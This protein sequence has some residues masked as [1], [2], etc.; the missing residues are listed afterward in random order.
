MRSSFYLTN[1]VIDMTSERLCIVIAIEKRWKD[2][3][4]NRRGHEQRV[5]LQSVDDLI[6]NF[7]CER[8]VLGQLQ[9]VLG[10][11]RLITSCDAAIDPVGL[12]QPLAKLRRLRFAQNILD[13][14]KH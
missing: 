1:G 12:I 7:T 2:F 10:F 13:M 11:S 9:I 14:K 4:G 3:Q 6:P 5:L 8:I